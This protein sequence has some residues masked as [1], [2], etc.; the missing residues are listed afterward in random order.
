M[1]TPVFPDTQWA[2]VPVLFGVLLLAP[3]LG[4]RW[5][6]SVEGFFAR[7]ASKKT[8]AVVV[9][10]IFTIALRLLFLPLIPMPVPGVHDEYVYLLQG[11]TF[12]HGRLANPPHPMWVSFET[13]HVNWLP[14][15]AGI[16]PPA[17]GLVLAIG[18]LLGHPWIGVLLS[19]AVMCAAVVWML[20]GWMPARW[21]LLGGLLVTL[22]F[23]LVSY[24]MNSYW[25]GA[26][27]AIGGALVLGALPRIHRQ[28]SLQNAVLLGLGAAIL[29]NSRPYEGFFFC[30]PVAAA[31]LVWLLRESSPPLRITVPRVVA[32]A[33]LVLALTVAFIGYYNW[34]LT[35]HPLLSPYILN[36]RTYHF[37]PVFLWQHA[38][39]PMHYHNREFAVYYNGWLHSGYRDTWRNAKY[40]TR[41]KLRRYAYTF[42]WPGSVPLLI[43]LPLVLRDRRF[44]LILVVLGFTAAALLALVWYM[45]HYAAPITC[46]SYG[47]LIQSLRH[48]RTLRLARW[49]LGLGLSRAIIALFLIAVG[50]DTYARISSPYEWDWNG[51]MGNSARAA[52]E[53][54]LEHT[55]GKHLVLVRYDEDHNVHEEWVYNGADIDGSKIVW[56]RQLDRVQN[57]KLLAYF[58]DRTVWTIAPDVRPLQLFLYARPQPLVPSVLAPR[59]NR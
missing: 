54:A 25:G 53:G 15:Y 17:Q 16:Y 58:H 49:P 46:A 48:V 44:R 41:A 9:I 8:T 33:A 30:L 56:A 57:G 42:L 36:M 38:G 10:F 4:D 18:M 29:A 27:A 23:G 1:N 50:M 20:Q 55:P 21:A 52:V 32:P 26:A 59:G 28:P 13:F 31:L 19:E 7:L 12:L 22:K 3:R 5:F 14:A 34:R 47:L 35:G 43:C 24:W 40:I 51:N 45:P 11:D 6:R 37:G 39:Q 2:P